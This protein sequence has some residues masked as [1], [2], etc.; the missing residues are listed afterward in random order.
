[1]VRDADAVL[2]ADLR[3]YRDFSREFPEEMGKVLMLGLFHG[4]P[5]LELLD[6]YHL[7]LVGTKAVLAQIAAAIE[8]AGETLTDR[9]ATEGVARRG[10]GG[11]ARSGD[12]GAH[13]TE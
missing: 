12:R 11:H 8:S 4:P 7:D 9:A 10:R 5:L 6:P 3:N 2:L 13:Q 1:M